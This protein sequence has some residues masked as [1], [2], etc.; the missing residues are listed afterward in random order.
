M[1]TIVI[2]IFVLMLMGCILAGLPVVFALIAGF[3]LFFCYGV[4]TGHGAGTMLKKAAGGIYTIR[5]ILE[6]FLMIGMLTALWREA[7]TIPSI[8][9]YASGLIRPGIM[10][11]MCFLL[12]CMISFLTGSSFA[13]TATMGVITMTMA[14]MAGVPVYLSGGA[15][16][17]GVYFGDRCAPVSTSALLIATLTKT[18]IFDNIK[19]CMKTAAVPF[20]ISCIV[21]GVLG[22]LTGAGTEVDLSIRELFAEEFRIGILPL[23]PAALILVL[24][25]LKVRVIKAML[26]SIAAAFLIAVFYQHAPVGRVLYDLLLGY[27]AQLPELSPMISGGGI[28]SMLSPAAIVSISSCYAGM[29]EETGL[30]NGLKKRIRAFSDRTVPFAGILVT[31][32]ITCAIA[33]N[34]TLS[35]MLTNQLCSELEPDH[36]RFAIQLEN[37][38][39]VIA[40]ML[41]WNIACA[42]PLAALGA[43]ALSI[44]F[45]CYLWLLPVFELIRSAK[46]K[47]AGM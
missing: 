24:A 9:Y 42:V 13:S 4:A 8:T 18:D 19:G 5:T 20:V 2:L 27:R 40:A 3:V 16:L 37:S 23:F 25:M 41:P 35:V 47:R 46:K 17:A 32:I 15:I 34:Q 28:R 43:P 12:N 26:A 29:F 38:V 33:C 31:G 22:A 21:Y 7:G 39:A 14:N 44:P 6:I 30:L 10:V 11:L 45:A 36:H 1:E